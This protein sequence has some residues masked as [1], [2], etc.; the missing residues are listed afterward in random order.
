M[1]MTMMMTIMMTMM[2]WPPALTPGVTHF[3]AYH[4][5]RDS[6]YLVIWFSEG[7]CVFKH[8]SQP[9]DQ[10]T[11]HFDRK[12][13]LCS[14]CD[15]RSAFPW[16]GGS[17]H[18]FLNLSLNL[19]PLIWVAGESAGK[20]RNA[21]EIDGFAISDL[22]LCASQPTF[23]TFIFRFTQTRLSQLNILLL[24]HLRFSLL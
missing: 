17:F 5:P 16:L 19:F 14:G 21:E 2:M 4:R 13:L 23:N 12:R 11:G 7:I 15:L 3:G 22:L 24:K 20:V 9:M 6:H 10:C 18:L 8:N 1:S